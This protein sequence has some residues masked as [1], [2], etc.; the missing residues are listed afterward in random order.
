MGLRVTLN[1]M[2]PKPFAVFLYNTN[3]K[4]AMLLRRC[5]HDEEILGRV[6]VGSERH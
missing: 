6:C 5:S 2:E 1:F 4:F 3:C